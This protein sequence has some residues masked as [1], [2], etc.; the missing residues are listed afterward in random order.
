MLLELIEKLKENIFIQ[1]IN[2]FLSSY[3][4]IFFIAF[5]FLLSNV[6]SI[7]FIVY[8]IIMFYTIYV[9][10]FYKDLSPIIPIAAMGYMSV[11]KKNNPFGYVEQPIFM[12][13]SYKIQL[14]VILVIMLLFLFTRLIFNLIRTKEKFTFPRLSLGF[15][16][17][18]FA[19]MIGGAFSGLYEFK[20]S[21]YGLVVTVSL[22]I[23]YFLFYFTVDFKNLKT[24]YFYVLLTS[25]GVMLSLQILNTLYL[26]GLFNFDVPLN[27]SDLYT[28]WGVNNNVGC[29]VLM[30]LPGPFALAIKKKNGW[31][32][33]LIGHF[34]MLFLILNQSRNIILLG[35]LFYL[36]INIVIFIYTKGKEKI[37]NIITTSVCIFI[38]IITVF[39]FK[40]EVANIFASLIKIGMNDSGRIEMYKTNLISSLD[41]FVFGKGFYNVP[42]YQWGD[43][44]KITFIP[45]RYHNTY[46]QL[47][48]S[49]GIVGLLAYFYHRFETL[50]LVFKKLTLNKVFVALS[51]LALPLSSILDCHFF[52]IGPG[53]L[54]GIALLFLEKGLLEKANLI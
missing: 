2:K 53:F 20:S 6:F 17:F 5:L 45:P 28:G 12:E 3:F 24:N 40:K 29:M 43:I 31:L 15:L 49:T 47:I 22:C 10:L 42:P 39:I 16:V 36:F 21:I 48:C 32:F 18:C 13:Q 44:E 54:Y 38:A 11:S 7:E 52:N 9:T 23:A 1:K 51:F 50:R 4:S 8:Y 46:V 35:I 25:A 41:T 30:C 19:S 34:N 37:G 27:R 33:N 26:A 14:L